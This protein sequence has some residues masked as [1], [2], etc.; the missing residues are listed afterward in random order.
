MLTKIRCLIT[1]ISLLLLLPGCAPPQ[2]DAETVHYYQAETGKPYEDVLAELE[3]AITENNF[4]ITGH[5]R[6][7]KVIRTRDDIEFPDYDTIQF[8]NLTHAQKLL[9]ISPHAIRYMPCN[10][11]TY[12]FERKTIVQIRLIPTDS[13]NPELNRFAREMNETLK[14]IVDFTVE[15]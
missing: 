3:I 10:V 15:E 6:V 2:P 5:S 7:G 8:C 11:V 1:I 13:D 14:S 9:Q 12:D 4:R